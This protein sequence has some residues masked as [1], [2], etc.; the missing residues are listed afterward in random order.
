MKYGKS[1]VV[2]IYLLLSPYVPRPGGPVGVLPGEPTLSALRERVFDS[3]ML[4]WERNLDI[5][6]EEN[7]MRC[8]DHTNVSDF[9]PVAPSAFTR[10][11][12]RQ[13]ASD[14]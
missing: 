6:A 10:D 8:G 14:G 11:P 5:I 3:P 13:I 7:S 12:G 4:G 2:G 1:L 9:L